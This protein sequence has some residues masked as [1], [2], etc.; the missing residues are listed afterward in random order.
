MFFFVRE[1]VNEEGGERWIDGE[2]KCDKT[3]EHGKTE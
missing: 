2:A 1:G 3:M